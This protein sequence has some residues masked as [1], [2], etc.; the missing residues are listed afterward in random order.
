MIYLCTTFYDA[1]VFCDVWAYMS[2]RFL[3]VDTKSPHPV[4]IRVRIGPPHPHACRKRRLNGAVLWM[5]PETPRS[6][7]TAGLAG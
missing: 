1:R 2:D 7:I 4:R 3:G 5:R 6:R